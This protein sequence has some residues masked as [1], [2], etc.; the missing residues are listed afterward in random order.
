MLIAAA[1]NFFEHGVNYQQDVLFVGQDVD[2]TVA[3]MAYVQAA[4]LGMAGY[5]VIGNSLTN[6]V[7]GDVLLPAPSEGYDIWFTPLYFSPVW[8]Q[9]RLWRKVAGIMGEGDDMGD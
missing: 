8:T 3:R 6:P 4:L 9:R 5:I 2:A 7:V 1:Q